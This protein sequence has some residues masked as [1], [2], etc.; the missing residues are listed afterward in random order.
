M[1]NLHKFC[2]TNNRPLLFCDSDFLKWKHDEEK[3]ENCFWYHSKS[4]KLSDNYVDVFS[5]NRSGHPKVSVRERKRQLKAQGYNKC[6]NICI[7]HL[8][9]THFFRSKKLKTYHLSY[10][11]THS[12]HNSECAKTQDLVIEE[13]PQ[14]TSLARQNASNMEEATESLSRMSSQTSLAEMSVIPMITDNGPVDKTTTSTVVKTNG[15]LNKIVANTIICSLPE[16]PV[17]SHTNGVQLA[18]SSSMGP[19]IALPMSNT[20][21]FPIVGS[22]AHIFSNAVSTNNLTNGPTLLAAN[23]GLNAI[24]MPITLHASPVISSTN[25]FNA[26]NV[27][28]V[29]TTPN[30]LAQSSV[31]REV[32]NFHNYAAKPPAT[33]EKEQQNQCFL[34][35]K[36]NADGSYF[37]VLNN[38]NAASS[39][40]IQ[41]SPIQTTTGQLSTS[42][43]TIVQSN[44]QPSKQTPTQVYINGTTTTMSNEGRVNGTALSTQS[45]LQ[46]QSEIVTQR[47]KQRLEKIL[48]R[49]SNLLLHQ[50]NELDQFLGTY[51]EKHCLR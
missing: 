48:N 49:D 41:S 40:G 31:S 24:Q 12:G 51:I 6:G 16:N 37:F 43:S 3:R 36:P 19:S 20:I 45:P 46:R 9:L 38:S 50:L 1:Q 26:S 5:C 4:Y 33:R 42:S 13:E 30:I 10:L 7:S 47:V 17:V 44:I 34:I 39:L 27:Q 14:G 28:I 15:C 8:R 18:G 32:L 11:K 29:T 23:P 21:T 35:D 25:T 22:N 2:L